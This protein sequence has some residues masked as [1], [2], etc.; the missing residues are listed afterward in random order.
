MSDVLSFLRTQGVLVALALLILFG[1]WRYDHFLGLFNIL[2]FLRY[3]SIFALIAL[4]MCFVIMTG[5]STC[6]SARPRRCRA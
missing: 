4:G 6:R 3:N 1:A 2:T 5:A